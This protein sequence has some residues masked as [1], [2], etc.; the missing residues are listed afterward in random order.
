MDRK[1]LRHSL[2]VFEGRLLVRG[3]VR[4]FTTYRSYCHH[5]QVVNLTANWSI[6][7][8]SLQHPLL[9]LTKLEINHRQRKWNRGDT[10]CYCIKLLD[11]C[12]VKDCIN[13]F[14]TLPFYKDLSYSGCDLMVFEILLP[15][16]TQFIRLFCVFWHYN[17]RDF[18]WIKKIFF[19]YQVSVQTLLVYFTCGLFFLLLLQ[20]CEFESNLWTCREDMVACVWPIYSVYFI[21]YK[22]LQS[23]GLI[24]PRSGEHFT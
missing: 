20:K 22:T 10:L 23:G 24:V 16:I 21:V 18:M 3:F 11:L 19:F 13:I 4:P 12:Y 14:A 7:L 5:S 9:A 2:W 17:S 1:H 6:K 15:D 8:H